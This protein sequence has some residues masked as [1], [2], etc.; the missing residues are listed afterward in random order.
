MQPWCNKQTKQKKIIKAAYEIKMEKFIIELC[1]YKCILSMTLH[2]YNNC[3]CTNVSHYVQ[4]P[5]FALT[6]YI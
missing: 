2:K 1:F 5:L 6:N 4:M 3:F